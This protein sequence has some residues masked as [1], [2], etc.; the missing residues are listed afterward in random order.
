MAK[1]WRKNIWRGV[2]LPGETLGQDCVMTQNFAAWRL[3]SRIPH[4]DDE[5]AR[6][7][8][9]ELP[10]D[11]NPV[12]ANVGRFF[13]RLWFTRLWVVQDFVLARKLVCICGQQRASELDLVGVIL[14]FPGAWIPVGRNF[15]RMP[16]SSRWKLVQDALLF[17]SMVYVRQARYKWRDFVALI[18]LGLP[19]HPSMASSF[20]HLDFY[21]LLQS[22]QLSS[23]SRKRNRYFALAGLALLADLNIDRREELRPDYE[24]PLNTVISTFGKF[25]WKYYRATNIP[26]TMLVNAGLE[27]QETPEVPSR[28]QDFTH[29]P[30]WQYEI[31]RYGFSI[32]SSVSPQ[33]YHH[34]YNAA[35][36][37]GILFHFTITPG[38]D[39]MVTLRGSCVDVVTPKEGFME[40]RK[41]RRIIPKKLSNGLLSVLMDMVDTIIGSG[42]GLR[43]RL[44]NYVADALVPGSED[45]ETP[46]AHIPASPFMKEEMHFSMPIGLLAMVL[47]VTSIQKSPRFETTMR[48]GAFLW[49]FWL[50]HRFRPAVNI[51]AAE[52][53]S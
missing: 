8:N 9:A 34:Y 19:P 49:Y 32:V 42:S 1:W 18:Q 48:K 17:R 25:L 5:K 43:Y 39:H 52:P 30:A 11:E 22:F 31:P 12:W 13:S 53:D 36:E 24:S 29:T 15:T 40:G 27:L 3:G 26:P 10:P 33:Q 47:N 2:L 37:G 7:L 23:S 14:Y 4:D 41:L 45:F 50:E 16:A 6:W 28:I 51:N 46:Q 38:L 20:L 35:G 21:S 44:A